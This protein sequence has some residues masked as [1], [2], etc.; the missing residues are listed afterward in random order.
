MSI[1]VIWASEA[2]TWV[3]EIPAVGP[4][5]LRPP[6]QR[7]PN[8]IGAVVRAPSV[9]APDR[10]VV[11]LCHEGGPGSIFGEQTLGEWLEAPSGAALRVAALPAPR[12]V[13]R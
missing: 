13:G 11:S 3:T 6:F 1:A 12:A 5:K 2:A 9:D 4:G 8:E 7:P 10:P